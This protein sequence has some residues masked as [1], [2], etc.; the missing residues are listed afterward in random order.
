MGAQ[1]HR[2]RAVGLPFA[3]VSQQKENEILPNVFRSFSSNLFSL[4][5]VSWALANGC[6]FCR[7]G[8]LFCEERGHHRPHCPA[9]TNLS[10][11]GMR[12]EKIHGLESG[13]TERLAIGSSM[14][15]FCV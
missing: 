12:R 9:G 2:P 15:L 11:T 5:Q 1:S 10:A 8:K 6:S 3:C 7:R 4:I 14:N 13:L